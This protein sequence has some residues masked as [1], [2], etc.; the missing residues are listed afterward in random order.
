M[1]PMAWGHGGI[2]ALFVGIV[3]LLNLWVIAQVVTQ[4]DAQMLAPNSSSSRDNIV[5]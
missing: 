3:S 2:E 4:G 5:P 1:W